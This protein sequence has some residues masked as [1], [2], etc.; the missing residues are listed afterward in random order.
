MVYFY[1]LLIF[2][3]FKI[4]STIFFM[5]FLSIYLHVVWSTKNREPFLN[6]ST[7]RKK[8]WKHIWTKAREKN[9]YVDHVNGF[10]DHCHCLISMNAN[11][12]TQEI[13]KYLKGESSNWINE[14]KLIESY[15]NWQNEYYA[16][17]ISKSHILKIRNYI[18]NQEEHHKHL[19]FEE[20]LDRLFQNNGNKLL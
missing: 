20:E 18:K 13:V 6:T 2:N 9:I 12:S 14:N 17:S 15:F 16:A 8:T 5:P 4:L 19:T 3:K 1:Y 11:Q 10:S 7:I